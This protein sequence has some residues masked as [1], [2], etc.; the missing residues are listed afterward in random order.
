LRNALDGV[1]VGD[2]CRGLHSAS[3]PGW[4]CSE[5]AEAVRVNGARA[6]VRGERSQQRAEGA[7]AAGHSHF[8][9]GRSR[10]GPPGPLSRTPSRRAQRKEARSRAEWKRRSGSFSG[11]GPQSG[12]AG[13]TVPHPAGPRAVWRSSAP[14]RWTAQAEPP[15]QAFVEHQSKLKIAAG[16]RLRRAPFQR[17]TP[18]SQ[19]G[20]GVVRRAARSHRARHAGSPVWP[21][22]NRGSGAPSRVGVMFPA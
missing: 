21:V 11:S 12:V 1:E 8:R 16:S 13:A 14:R 15:G 4:F 17:H 3:L 10:A 18:R 20:A 7:R 2:V 9:R 19:H 5:T 22:R 6:R